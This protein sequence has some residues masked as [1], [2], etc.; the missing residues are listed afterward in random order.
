MTTDNP[1]FDLYFI[2]S[3]ALPRGN[4]IRVLPPK[5]ACKY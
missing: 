3:T 5:K 1:N 4:Q 2:I